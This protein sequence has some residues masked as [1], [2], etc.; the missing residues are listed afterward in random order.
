[1]DGTHLR[2]RFPARFTRCEAVSQRDWLAV[3]EFRLLP[4]TLKEHPFTTAVQIS[5][6]FVR[7]DSFAYFQHL[8]T[9]RS[10]Y[11]RQIWGQ[12]PDLEAF[13]H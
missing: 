7:R 6:V 2:S 10:S 9:L 8:S 11:T 3:E 13:V 5:A 1:M 4:Q 12:R